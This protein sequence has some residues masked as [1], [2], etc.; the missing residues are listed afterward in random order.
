MKHVIIAPL[1]PY[2]DDLF[3]GIREFPTER[4]I[5]VSSKEKMKEAEATKKKLEQFRIPCTIK[6]IRSDTHI[7]EATFEAI[8][9]IKSAE[10]DKELLINVS[11]GDRETRC[12]ATSAAFVNGIKAFGV[13]G[14]EAMLLPV[15]KFS[16]YK[17]LTDKKLDILKVLASNPKCCSSLD[18]L[19]KKTNMS[20]PLISYH[21]NGTLKSE[22]L[23]ELGLI[24]TLEK[25]GRMEI[26]LSMMGRLLVKGY[27]R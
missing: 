24:E 3:V 9:Q 27:I 22:G 12:A 18:E 1:G 7:W 15:L 17:M 11:T 2:M 5:L 19:S 21:I 16:Y 8:A 6:E 23:K 25:K 13:E 14:N 26:N 20:L 10:K 4:I